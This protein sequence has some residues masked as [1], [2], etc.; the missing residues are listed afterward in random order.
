MVCAGRICRAWRGKIY[1]TLTVIGRG[2]SGGLARVT[3]FLFGPPAGIGIDFVVRARFVEIL[4]PRFEWCSKNKILNLHPSLLSGFPGSSAY[5]RACES[6]VKLAGVPSHCV[7]L[8]LV[9]DPIIAR[10]GCELRPGMALN[11]IIATG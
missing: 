6:G 2:P 9:E 5:R 11:E 1:A 7:S 10:G 4:S 3:S 8:H